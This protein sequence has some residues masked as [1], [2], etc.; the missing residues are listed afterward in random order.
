MQNHTY[1]LVVISM[2]TTGCVTV[3][4]ADTHAQHSSI[5]MANTRIALGLNYIKLEQYSK[6]RQSLEKAMKYAPHYYKSSLSLA[7]YFDV[8]GEVDKAAALY[9]TTLKAHPNNGSVYN[10]YGTFLCKQ[11]E[12]QTADV[13]FNQAINKPNYYAV[14]ETYENAGLCALKAHKS[15]QAKYYFHKS[16]EHQPL[17]PIASLQLAA[18]EIEQDQLHQA[19]LRLLEFSQRYGYQ[20]S[21][22]ALLI[23]LERKSD[24]WV[25]VNKYQALLELENGSK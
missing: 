15:Q 24:N 16:V 3:P 1:F 20:R 19:R 12:Y 14:A 21:N 8:V 18:I 7:Y 5:D 23:D 17:R 22:L 25:L 11:G 4:G 2:I 6:A 13:L 10:N 9:H